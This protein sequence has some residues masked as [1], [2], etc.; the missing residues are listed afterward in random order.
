MNAIVVLKNGH[1]IT[2]PLTNSVDSFISAI[3]GGVKNDVANNYYVEGPLML[4]FADIA[5]IHP[6]GWDQDK[7]CID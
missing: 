2:V 5:A 4:N 6:E 3:T 1:K 7:D